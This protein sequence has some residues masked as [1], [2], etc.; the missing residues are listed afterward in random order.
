MKRMIKMIKISL[1]LLLVGMAVIAAVPFLKEKE[2]GKKSEN[3]FKKIQ[4]SVTD[5]EDNTINVERLKR[6]NEDCIGYLEVPETTIS[7]PVM[8]TRDNPDFYLKHDF[9][10][11]YSFYGTPYLSAYCDLKKSDNLIIYGHNINGGK[12]F[13]ALEQ[14]KDKDFFDK[15]RKIYFTTDRRR[16]YEV[17]A[18]MSVNVK[19]FEYW[20][21]VMARDKKDYDDFVDK[22]LGHSLWNIG[23]RPKYGEQMMMLSTCDNGKGDAWRI[24]VVG[25]K[26]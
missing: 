9:N 17:L 13:E 6:E 21:F 8:Q 3:G 22:V 19:E 24:V 25:K 23:E 10:K 15:H 11:N 14:Y 1:I 16:E 26:M 20:K 2:A 7:Y 12:M 18:V 5:E 4:E